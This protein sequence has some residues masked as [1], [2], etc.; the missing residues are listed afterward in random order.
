[1]LAAKKTKLHIV[2][3]LINQPRIQIY[4]RDQNGRNAAHYAI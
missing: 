4:P 2:E 1:M 3:K